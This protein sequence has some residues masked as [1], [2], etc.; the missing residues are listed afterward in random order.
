MPDYIPFSM[1]EG[2]LTIC[3]NLYPY[4]EYYGCVKGKISYSADAVVGTP[5]SG[6]NCRGTDG[7]RYSFIGTGTA[8]YRLENN[9]TMTDVSKA[10][11]YTSGLANWAWAQYGDWVIATNGI[12]VPQVLKGMTAAAF[13]D[14]GGDPPIARYVLF[15]NGHLIFGYTTEVGV[16]YPKRLQWSAYESIED[17]VVSLSTGAAREDLNDAN[18]AITGLA[19][20]GSMF[21]VGHEQSITVG[22]YS[23]GQYYPFAF[24][25]NKIPNIGAIE[26]TMISIGDEILFWSEKDIHRFNGTTY[27]DIGIGVRHTILSALDTANYYRITTSH[28]V[29]GGIVM[30]AHTSISSADGTPNIILVYNYRNPKYSKINL[31]VACIFNVWTGAWDMDSMDS[32]YPNVDVIAIDFDSN[33]W[34]A[35]TPLIGVVDPDDSKVYTLDGIALTGQVET[36][37]L[38]T[39]T[40]NLIRRIRPMIQNPDTGVLG[41]IQAKI[42][43]RMKNTA[44]HTDSSYMTMQPSGNI[45]LRCIGRQIR[46][47]MTMNLHGGL[48][49]FIEVDGVIR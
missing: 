27:T 39:G 35:N 5:R 44:T 4:D 49:N 10:G 30:W 15:K 43:H 3:E 31:R 12:D 9:K 7:T 36:G 48:A 42:R 34:R 8:L 6:F 38:D 40:V 19:H 37:D 14:L 33:F 47:N 11:G 2:G 26:N 17:Y 1:P 29:K 25:I 22:Y 24:A 18:G 32:V 28:N 46:I 16:I 41:T 23:S 21:A 20:L 13:E 45:F